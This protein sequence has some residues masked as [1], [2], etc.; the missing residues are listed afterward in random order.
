MFATTARF[1][2][3]AIEPNFELGA[4]PEFI[5]GTINRPYRGAP[6]FI[7]ADVTQA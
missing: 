6:A 5:W 2:V 7:H 4:V 1:E 3:E